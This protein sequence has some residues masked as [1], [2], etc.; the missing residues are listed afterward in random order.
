MEETKEFEYLDD[1]FIEEIK[2]YKYLDNDFIAET[3]KNIIM[4]YTHLD[5]IKLKNKISNL[6][7]QC[8]GLIT[9]TINID[10]LKEK[11]EG[12]ALISGLCTSYVSAKLYE[13]IAAGEY[14]DLASDL[15]VDFRDTLAKIK[16]SQ[17]EEN[18]NL[19]ESKPQ[20]NFSLYVR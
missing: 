8:I 13:L 18:I 4:D 6:E 9:S 10:I 15:M 12:K 16:E 7:L 19:D 17:L 5:K 20:K 11:V 2:E 1:E 3:S 14:I